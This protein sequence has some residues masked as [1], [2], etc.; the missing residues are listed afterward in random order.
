MHGIIFGV[1][2]IIIG[3]ALMTIKSHE[4]IKSG[5]GT[6]VCPD[7][8]KP[9]KE[10]RA[11]RCVFCAHA[12]RWA[13]PEER[14]KTG[15]AIK[16]YFE[17]HPEAREK[18][19]KILRDYWHSPT[20]R[21]KQ[22]KVMKKLFEDSRL[23]EKYSK[24][25]KKRCENP[26]EHQKRSD[27]TKKR[28]E[29]N[30]EIW[31]KVSGSNSHFWRGGTSFEPYGI[32]FNPKIRHQIRKRDDYLCQKCYLPENGCFHDIHH[33]DFIKEHNDPANLIALCHS[34]HSKTN[35][36]NKDY[37]TEFFQTIQETRGLVK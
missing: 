25:Q 1:V 7:C 2:R 29:K 11:E 14:A 35:G 24:A 26:K 16:K 32:E 9:K 12:N 30:P 5:I 33:I 10:L 18:Q 27:M 6:Y 37:W 8:L 28:F 31:L 3:A 19:N 20:S 23:R 13:N 21:E 36:R 22:S 17:I 4:E 15:R 34:C